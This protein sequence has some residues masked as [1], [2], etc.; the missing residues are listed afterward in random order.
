MLCCYMQPQNNLLVC[1]ALVDMYAKAGQLSDAQDCFDRIYFP[2][3][4]SWNSLISAY[5]EHFYAED[6]LRCFFQM[7][8]EGLFPDAITLVCVL[9]AC[10]SIDENYKGVV[11]HAS[12]FIDKWIEKDIVVGY[13]LVDMY[14]K[15]GM[16]G[17][18][19]RV[20]DELRVKDTGSWNALIGG[21]IQ[22]GRFKEAFNSFNEM[23][24]HGHSA[25]EVTSLS[26]LKACGHVRDICKGESIHKQLIMEGLLENNVLLGA[27]LVDMYAKCGALVKAKEVFNKLFVR[28][29]VVW[30]A[31]ITGYAEHGFGEEALHCFSLMQ[32]EGLSPDRITFLSVLKACGSIVGTKSHCDRLYTEIE[33]DESLMGN[34]MISTALMDMFGKHGALTKVQNLFQQH[35]SVKNVVTW[36]ALIS[37]YVRHGHMEEAFQCLKQMQLEGIPA[38]AITFVGILKACGD[39][40]SIHKG[41]EAHTQIVTQGLLEKEAIVG[42]ALVG[43]YAQFGMLEKAHEVYNDL[44]DQ[45]GV[46]TPDICNL[47]LFGYAEHGFWE[48]ALEY[49]EQMQLQGISLDGMTFVCALKACGNLG[50]VDKGLEVH[51]H[52]TKKGLIELD[53]VLGNALADMYAKCGLI[54]EAHGVFDKLRARDVVTWTS[55][56]TGYAQIGDNETVFH[57]FERMR[58]ECEPPNLMTFVGVLTACSHCGLVDKGEGYF[59]A[60]SYPSTEHY[61]CLLDILGRAGQLDKAVTV[62]N[63]MP[64]HPTLMVWH[65][66][67]GACKKWGNLELARDVFEFVMQLDGKDAASFVSMSNIYACADMPEGM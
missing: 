39:I 5:S 47:L 42:N 1:N 61:S 36:T 34:I 6:A 55:L 59:E 24:K 60:I 13:A 22:R 41:K 40:G 7:Q 64:F 16:L 53:L 14:A 12:I 67:F 10:V 46:R 35:R 58:G 51:G 25:N 43:M 27:A 28:D 63:K 32:N 33:H 8:A 11:F 9:K 15:K 45:F 38:N 21:Y 19:Q 52:I 20:F 65:V 49:I 54:R 37:A 2:D 29:V 48:E 56:I 23:Q 44:I 18:S 26:I 4:I 57:L 62:I 31:L 66:V 50:A 30:N 17:R 3:S